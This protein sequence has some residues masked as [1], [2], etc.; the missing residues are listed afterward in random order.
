MIEYFNGTVFNTDEKAIV[1]TV[2][3]TG[4]MGAGLALEFALRYPNMLTDYEKKCESRM[5]Q[6][7][8]VDYFVDNDIT[9]INF[10]TK[11]HF[12]YPSKKI[13]IEDGLKNFVKSYKENNIQSVA[14]PKLGTYNGGLLWDEIKPLMETY[15]KGL[16]IKVYICLDN[17]NTAD[18]VEAEMIN[19]FSNLKLDNIKKELK[20][21]SKQVDILKQ[22]QFI[23]RFWKIKEL[24]GIGFS[25]YKKIF[26]YC[27]DL[28]K[29]KKAEQ[30]SWF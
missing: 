2:N 9:I 16:D 1:N 15:L 28:I 8:L 24:E 17:E 19:V 21:S 13:W 22:N 6:V 20:L 18:G 27:Y 26:N 5:I 12:K 30:I 14:F 11:W 23:N 4:V 29:N 3:C 10:P 25:T 7:G